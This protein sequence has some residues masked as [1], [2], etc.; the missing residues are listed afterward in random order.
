MIFSSFD[1]LFRF[2]PVFLFLYFACPERH[3][4]LCL[5][6]GSLAFY[7][8][9]VKDNPLYFLLFAVSIAVNF[10]VGALIGRRNRGAARGRWLAVG[11]AYNLFWLLLFKYSAFFAENLNQ[12]FSLLKVGVTL[13][14]YRPALPIGISFYT[15]QAIAYLAD[16]YRREAK[17][18]RSF[19]NFGMYLGM[20][21]H[22]ISGPIV[23]YPDEAEEISG[24][25]LSAGMVESGL[26]ELTIG[27]G[28]KVLIADRLGGLWSQVGA[29]GYDSISTPLAWMGAAAYSLQLYFDFC[30]YSLMAVGLGRI[31]GFE[32]P[33]NFATPYMS[34]S[35]TEF[36]RRWHIT[37]GSW[38]R[39][40]VYIPLGGNRRGTA[41]MLRNMLAVWLLTGFWHGASWNFLFWGL[42]LFALMTLE[43]L[44]LARLFHRVPVLGH[45]YM[46]LAIPLTWMIFAIGDPGQLA[47]YFQRLFPFLEG[48]KDVMYFA[49]D[50]LK[51]GRLYGISLAAGL[52]FMTGWPRRLYDR[53]RNTLVTAVILLAVFWVSVYCIQ[54]GENDP[55]LYFSF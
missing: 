24:R 44:G 42:T 18:E 13:P 35:M 14:V 15:F 28:Y 45:L 23:R 31:L 33:Q 41:V 19:V 25:G 29:I 5:F 30:G 27:L 48:G 54:M 47:V 3:R 38:F 6:A 4:N 16:V 21:P 50:Y 49:G 17:Y 39:D 43:K 32:L 53:Y 36:W 26:R 22:L 7:F 12:M 55:F 51:Y 2:L 10:Q 40:Y 1:F 8:Y 11:V 52:I 46:M 9:G 34:L 37:L 20:F